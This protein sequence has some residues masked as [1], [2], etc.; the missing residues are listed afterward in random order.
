M[1]ENEHTGCFA[2]MATHASAEAPFAPPHP[3]ST[4]LNVRVDI[5]KLATSVSER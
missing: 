1:D 2:K 4:A 3:M 5:T